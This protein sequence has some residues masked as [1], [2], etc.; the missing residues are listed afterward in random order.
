MLQK[1][2]NIKQIQLGSRKLKVN[3]NAVSYINTKKTKMSILSFPRCRSS[4]DFVG[5]HR[6]SRFS[7][8]RIFNNHT[9]QNFCTFDRFIRIIFSQIC[10]ISRVGENYINIDFPVIYYSYLPVDTDNTNI[11][12]FFS[13]KLA[14]RI[15]Y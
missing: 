5:I 15:I 10:H 4:L 11:S 13:S 6:L 9:V 12:I 2:V 3:R 1:E 8:H 7:E 14:K